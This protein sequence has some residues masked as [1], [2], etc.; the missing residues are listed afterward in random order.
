M[1]IEDGLAT[2][3]TVTEE[4]KEEEKE[5]SDDEKLNDEELEKQSEERIK[6]IE[7]QFKVC[8]P[9]STD[10]WVVHARSWVWKE[11][12]HQPREGH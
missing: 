9:L 4:Q 8:V 6:H 2:K 1:A 3:E 5:E 11:R 12:Q 7:E 10:E